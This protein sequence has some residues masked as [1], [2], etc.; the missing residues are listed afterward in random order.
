MNNHQVKEIEPKVIPFRCPVCN[1]FGT[2]KH[3]TIECHACKGKGYVVIE[4]ERKID[5][6]EPKHKRDLD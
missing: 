4:N 6:N 1:G 3:G 2:L 5:R